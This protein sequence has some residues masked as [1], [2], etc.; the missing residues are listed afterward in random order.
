[1]T[2]DQI[3]IAV[4]SIIG[5]IVVAIIIY[6]LIV[7][8]YQT[9]KNELVFPPADYMKYVGAQCPNMWDISATFQGNVFC[10]NSKNINVEKASYSKCANVNC[11]DTGDIKI[12]K[13]VNK[14]PLSKKDDILK[15]RCLWRD[16][17]GTGDDKPAAWIG[18]DRYC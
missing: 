15:S 3:I 1:M 11:Y 10:K 13:Q 17:C 14:W 16:C 7:K 9:K 18:L 5:V 4:F 8:L 12:F 2:S 6:Y